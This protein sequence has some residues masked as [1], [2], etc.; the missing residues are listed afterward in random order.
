MLQLL[1][2]TISGAAIGCIYAL[3]AL[4][5]VLIYKAT[6]TVN[7]AQGDIMM[8]GGF[9][10][11]T[12]MTVGGLPF[13][14][15]FLITVVAMTLFGM[16][17]ERL[18]LRPLLGQP[19]F[20]VVMVTIG[21][22]YLARGVVTMIP[23]WGTETHS[24]PVPYKDEVIWLGGEGKGLVVSVEHLVIIVATV[25]LSSMISND[26]VMPVL[27]R[28]PL[29]DISQRRDLPR[30]MRGIRRV[31]RPNGRF[32]VL[33]LGERHRAAHAV[34]VGA[35][36]RADRQV[37]RLPV[38]HDPVHALLLVRVDTLAVV[39]AHALGPHDLR[40]ADGAPLAGA[41]ADLAALAL[42]PA[43]DAEERRDL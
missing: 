31:L 30:L 39:A 24:L 42:R 17:T 4:G 33:G 12:A 15:A 25:A 34:A 5:F 21:I 35:D 3:I 7:F 2:L 13:W 41:L 26:L 19:A 20:T 10:G 23:Y 27:L 29:L 8:I 37:L 6:E 16:G 36:L 11:L 40:P 14:A 22:G 1:Q 9:V 38:Y 43:L 28:V 18:V 32:V